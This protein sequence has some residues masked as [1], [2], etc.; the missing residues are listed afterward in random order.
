MSDDKP[1]NIEY[2]KLKIEQAKLHLEEERLKDERKYRVLTILSIFIPLLTI[3]ITIASNFWSQN[4]QAEIDFVLRSVEV[5]INS[6]DPAEA[7][8]KLKALQ[9]LFPDQLP[10]DF[11]SVL[12]NFEPNDFSGG[13]SY[14]NKM[15]FLNL[16]AN[17]EA[18]KDDVL[19]MYKKLFPDSLIIE[20]IE[21]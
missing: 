2:E 10:D 18:S 15:N 20:A 3:A 11:G 8:N 17:S 21:K 6:D 7:D 1:I 5:V 4:K 13:P 16:M 14:E 19:E 9:Y 12:D